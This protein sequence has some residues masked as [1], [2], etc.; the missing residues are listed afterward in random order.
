MIMTNESSPGAILIKI[1]PKVNLQEFAQ[2][3][4]T[5]GRNSGRVKQRFGI[6]LSKLA[7]FEGLEGANVGMDRGRGR[8]ELLEDQ[9]QLF[10][11]CAAGEHWLNKWAN[12]INKKRKS[13]GDG[14]GTLWRSIS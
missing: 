4:G 9:I 6:V 3:V 13:D 11:R 14:N 5:F 2:Q 12:R 8:A 7:I 10:I 1:S